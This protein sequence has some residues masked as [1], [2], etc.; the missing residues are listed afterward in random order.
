MIF[1]QFCEFFIFTRQ[2]RNGILILLF[3]LFLTLCADIAIPFIFPEKEYDVSAWKEEAEKYHAGIAPAGETRENAFKG[4]VDPNLAG[5]KELT[6]LGIPA[7]IA[8]NWVKYLQ[9]GGRF[10]KKEEV[11]KLYGM[12]E[13][14]YLK[15]QGNL[16]VTKH[17]A[18][19][20]RK[21]DTARQNPVVASGPFR[22]DSL[23]KSPD[24][25]IKDTP[26]LEVNKADS[27]QLEALPGIGPVLASRIIK[28]RSLLGGFHEI[29]Q[30]KEIYGMSEELWIKSSVRL[31]A[32]SS[33]IKKI[34][35]N[36]LSLTELGRHPYIGFKQARKIVK[37]RDNNGKFTRMADLTPLFTADSLQHLAPYLSIRVPDQ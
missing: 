13:E 36:F 29:A 27:V 31:H 1:K 2:E 10:K 26:S 34:D 14:L 19:V 24:Y 28:Y 4:I 25:E 7:G 35:L 9:K 23:W 18:T 8:G 11:M 37:Q 20:K 22:K 6:E 5:L 17:A 15:V 3:I 33:G 21:P 32:D 12:T 16:Q 30:L